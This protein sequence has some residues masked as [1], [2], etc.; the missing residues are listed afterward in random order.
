MLDAREVARM[1]RVSEDTVRR[2]ARAGEIPH[3]RLG[4]GNRRIYRFR[5]KHIEK[6]LDAR[7]RING[8]SQEEK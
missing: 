5:K 6:W 8:R 3:L 2:M 7:V 1:L 4:V